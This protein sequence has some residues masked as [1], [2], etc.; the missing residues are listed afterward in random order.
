MTQAQILYWLEG[1][2]QIGQDTGGRGAGSDVPVGE[3]QTA[4]G[5]QPS[6]GSCSHLDRVRG[7][8]R[9]GGWALECGMSQTQR[10]R[11]T[12]FPFLCCGHQVLLLLEISSD[13]FAPPGGSISSLWGSVCIFK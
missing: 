12:A 9:M 13:S 4:G 8:P 3:S 7:T 1:K 6:V 11:E 2:P 10:C 5:S